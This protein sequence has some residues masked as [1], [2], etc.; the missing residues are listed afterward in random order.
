MQRISFYREKLIIKQNINEFYEQ[1]DIR[2]KADAFPFSISELYIN[3]LNIK[4]TF[5][6]YI[7]NTNEYILTIHV[8]NNID[9]SLLIKNGWLKND[10]LET[11]AKNTFKLKIK[12]SKL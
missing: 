1:N 9:Q 5:S 2:R 7:T 3:P 4:N 11:L 10:S 6:V 8:E 12:K